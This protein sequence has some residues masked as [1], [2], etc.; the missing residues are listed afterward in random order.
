MGMSPVTQRKIINFTSGNFTTYR[1]HV[2]NK[3]DKRT[4]GDA[5]PT[6]EMAELSTIMR[7][8]MMEACP[9]RNLNIM[10][11]RKYKGLGTTEKIKESIQETAEN[12]HRSRKAKAD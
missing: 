10:K 8:A 3:I 4:W 5:P 6:E 2:E 9:T 11:S 1:E 7:D 12:V